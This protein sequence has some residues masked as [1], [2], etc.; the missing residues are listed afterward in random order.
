MLH[1]IFKSNTIPTA[2]GELQE[3]LAGL[4][5]RLFYVVVTFGAVAL[6]TSWL[7]WPFQGFHGAF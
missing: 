5:D 3:T 7:R 4:M 2:S 6:I 1:S